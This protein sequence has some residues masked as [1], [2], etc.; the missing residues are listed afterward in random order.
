M[1]KETKLQRWNSFLF[2]PSCSSLITAVA[3]HQGPNT[4]C[5]DF[6]FLFV[7]T[8][9]SSLF[10]LKHIVRLNIIK[11]LCDGFG[12]QERS[13]AKLETIEDVCIQ[14]LDQTEIRLLQMTRTRLEH[15]V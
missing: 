12:M 15:F 5:F 10:Y 2:F 13:E 14:E 1:V 6:S 7:C 8:I 3:T 11:G 9:V 4:F